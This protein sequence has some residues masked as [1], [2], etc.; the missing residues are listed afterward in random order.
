MAD[1]LAK[2]IVFQ[3]DEVK[4]SL[5]KIGLTYKDGAD[6]KALADIVYRN[7][8]NERLREDIVRIITRNHPINIQSLFPTNNRSKIQTELDKLKHSLMNSFDLC[9]G[10]GR[11]YPSTKIEVSS[12]ESTT[13]LKTFSLSATSIISI[14]LYFYLKFE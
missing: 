3:S 9:Y 11:V 7:K 1:E 12:L 14:L 8:D 2:V 13:N 6:E 5:V 4:K 10:I